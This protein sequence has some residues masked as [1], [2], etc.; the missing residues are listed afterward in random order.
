MTKYVNINGVIHY[1]PNGYEA[2]KVVVKKA[3][4]KTKKA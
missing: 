4:K 1:Y 2:E 3:A